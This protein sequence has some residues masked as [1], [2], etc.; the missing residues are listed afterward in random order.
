MPLVVFSRGITPEE[1]RPESLTSQLVRD[2]IDTAAEPLRKLT[3][4]DLDAADRVILFNQLPGGLAAAS[5]EDWTDL[6]SMI[7]NYADTRADLDRRI[8]DL[9]SRLAR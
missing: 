6:P 9:L 2:G 7:E 4:A 8:D 3:Q 1:H 5:I